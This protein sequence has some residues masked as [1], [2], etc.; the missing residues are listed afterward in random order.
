MNATAVSRTVQEPI[1]AGDPRAEPRAFRRCLGQFATGVTV[2]TTAHGDTPVGMAVNSFAAVS[3]DPPLILWSVR[4]ESRSLPA[5]LET[6]RF[7]VN[8]LSADQVE[9]SQAFGSGHPERFSLAPWSAG[10]H[11]GAPLL[12]DAVAHLECRLEA[13]HE[14]GDHLILVGHVEQYA[15]FDGSPLLFAQGTYAVAD[16]HPA[17]HDSTTDPGPAEAPA[18]DTDAL[19]TT[20]LKDAAHRMSTLF[21]EHRHTI[22]V[23]DVTSRVVNRLGAGPCGSEELEHATYLGRRAVE[24]ALAELVEQGHAGRDPHG[25][26]ELTA[27]GR[28]IG[29]RLRHSARMFTGQQLSGIPEADIAA[30]RRVL[31][32]LQPSS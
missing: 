17:G 4:R 22:G 24:D 10:T 21:D 23:N 14:G 7:A 31:L 2:I 13:V 5:F 27:S 8:V 11:S 29:Q 6:A 18:T 9:V 16:D 19:F 26:Y 1:E 28:R 15:R 20:L 30:A 3:L 25:R 32:A 12:D